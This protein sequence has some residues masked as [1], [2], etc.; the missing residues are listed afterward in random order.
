MPKKNRKNLN[1]AFENEMKNRIRR[2]FKKEQARERANLDREKFKEKFRSGYSFDSSEPSAKIITIYP[3][4]I[5]EAINIL[6]ITAENIDISLI[7]KVYRKLALIH[8]PDK[9]T[10]PKSIEI[11]KK[12]NNAN[13]ILMSHFMK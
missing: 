9:S 12:I 5:M 11:M 6:G 7:K 4:N 8:H 10:D 1:K 13:E 3:E 2:E